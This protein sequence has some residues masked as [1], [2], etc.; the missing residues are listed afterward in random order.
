[1]KIKL[2]R[3]FGDV[4]V[5]VAALSILVASAFAV[6]HLQATAEICSTKNYW[7]CWESDTSSTLPAAPAGFGEYSTIVV[8][9]DTQSIVRAAG[10]STTSGW[11]QTTNGVN[12]G[13][14]VSHETYT[15]QSYGRFNGFEDY[16]NAFPTWIKDHKNSENIQLVMPLGDIING[17]DDGTIAQ[18][19]AA[20]AMYDPLY[21]VV[22]VSFVPGNHDYNWVDT[23]IYESL[24]AAKA[25]RGY[26]LKAG[27]E[28]GTYVST[29][30]CV[31]DRKL[32][33]MQV[34]F[35][36][37]KWGEQNG[38]SIEYFDDSGCDG[39][40]DKTYGANAYYELTIG[41]TNYLIMALEYM[42]RNCVVSWANAEINEHSDD[43]III[44]T[45]ALMKNDSS[46]IL[47][48]GSNQDIYDD[49]EIG[50]IGNEPSSEQAKISYSGLG[51]FNN[52]IK[53]HPNIIMA[54]SGHM[55]VEYGYDADH[56]TESVAPNYLPARNDQ[57]GT[58]NATT[59]YAHSFLA[60]LQTMEYDRINLLKD[61]A[62]N[63]R[64]KPY[65]M[66]LMVRI[67][68]DGTKTQMF[69]C[70]TVQQ[71]CSKEG[72]ITP[73]K[74]PKPVISVQPAS[75]AT[76]GKAT[77]VLA[78]GWDATTNIIQVSTDNGVSWRTDSALGS[79]YGTISNLT[80]SPTTD[81][82]YL[83]RAV[84]DTT[85]KIN[86]S[87]PVE[88]VVRAYTTYTITFNANGG[89]SVASQ[90][91]DSGTPATEPANPTRTNYSFAG[92]YSNSGLTNSY[93]FSNPVVNNVTLYA[94]W[95]DTV[96]P[97]I[98]INGA[99]PQYIEVKSGAFTDQLGASAVDAV[100]GAVTVTST[101]NVNPNLLG[102]YTITY[103][104]QDAAGNKSTATRQVIVRDTTAPVLTVSPTT[105]IA[106]QGA[107]VDLMS[108]VSAT[109]NYDSGAN[110]NITYASAPTFNANKV[111]IY[112]ITYSATDSS[113][114]PAAEK[115]RT[116]NITDGVAPTASATYS[117]DVPTNQ[118]ITVTISA[119]ENLAPLDGWTKIDDKH[120]TKVYSTNFTG[121]QEVCDMN[122]NCV[123][124]NIAISNIDKVA[125]ELT[126]SYSPNGPTKTAT[127]VV[128]TIVSD[129]NLANLPAGW[130]EVADKTYQKTFAVNV[131]E[132]VVFA[133]AAGNEASAKIVI[134]WIDKTPIDSAQDEPNGS[135]L[136]KEPNTIND[137][138][139]QPDTGF[140]AIARN[141]LVVGATG[142]ATAGAMWFG[143]RR[144][145]R[146]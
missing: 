39:N 81:T 93:N 128:A 89:S 143:T 52:L 30:G 130:V 101:N 73:I 66:V 21:N 107:N 23:N 100:D 60:D 97:V 11:A 99:N 12:P 114:N 15:C 68:K 55:D 96:K 9:P 110:I 58:G 80:P 26:C 103:S 19:R 82:T 7:E 32:S 106:K 105:V 146:Q 10:Y 47:G 40:T 72:V 144:R 54:F 16:V 108:G 121:V 34:F 61:G 137:S 14:C 65:G 88:V 5:V 44:Q 3:K 28:S 45:H 113:G 36:L 117:T 67:A 76:G 38:V 4:F 127:D 92:W 64:G 20:R 75:S 56:P 43:Q 74:E 139:V 118:D 79:S 51:L 126:L 120:F 13:P 33:V 116:V 46:F 50:S 135:D 119:D 22:P 62:S 49:R 132:T 122:N 31:G 83:V 95:N 8:V 140:A 17:D 27:S 111:G 25:V 78:K 104:A 37:S 69:Y 6:N 109:D 124:V 35:P 123:D 129:E 84:A 86:A 134:S 53:L 102:T 63:L 138:P 24:A 70:S 131:D 136:P 42:P 87:D 94:K 29:I 125:P 59:Y 2:S 90:T 141:P 133:D 18:W 41:D 115:T 1:M 71:M 77:V 145:A 112:T 48:K 85:N 98:T 57:V 91:V 142:L